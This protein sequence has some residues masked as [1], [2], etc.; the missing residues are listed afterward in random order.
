MHRFLSD[1]FPIISAPS[2]DFF[3][4]RDV[5]F[6]F[7]VCFRRDICTG[8]ILAQM[9][10]PSRCHDKLCCTYLWLLLIQVDVMNTKALQ[11]KNVSGFGVWRGLVDKMRLAMLQKFN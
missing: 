11:T 1:K 3:L 8:D 2:T 7:R 9:D 5:R 4:N 10:V 6:N